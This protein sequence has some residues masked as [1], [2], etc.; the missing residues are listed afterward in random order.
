VKHIR[1][2]TAEKANLITPLADFY[3]NVL[4]AY[5]DLKLFMKFEPLPNIPD[6]GLVGFPGGDNTA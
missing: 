2:V 5:E 1:T 4:R 3:F 6:G